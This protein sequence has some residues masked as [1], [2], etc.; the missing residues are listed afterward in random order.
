MEEWVR[1]ERREREMEEK[2]AAAG[3]IVLQG[4][5]PAGSQQSSPVQEDPV[6]KL[7][8][9]KAMLDGGLITEAEYEAKKADILSRM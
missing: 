3:G 1:E 4:P 7:T 6:K 2:R 9:L 5:V 8:Q